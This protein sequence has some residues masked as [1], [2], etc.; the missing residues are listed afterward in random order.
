MICTK[1]MLL[2]IS[3]FKIHF[4]YSQ[5]ISHF[6]FVRCLYLKKIQAL[7]DA[8]FRLAMCGYV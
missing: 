6:A 2:N 1:G 4:Y 7:T 5:Y 8:V 3:V